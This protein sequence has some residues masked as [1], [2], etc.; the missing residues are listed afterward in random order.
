MQ[1]HEVVRKAGTLCQHQ[2][3]AGNIWKR[4]RDFS[5]KI[6]IYYLVASEFEKH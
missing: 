3:N 2:P 6:T 5:H 1:V 4:L